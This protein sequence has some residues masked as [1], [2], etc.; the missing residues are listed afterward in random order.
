MS[1]VSIFNNEST[2]GET[3]INSSAIN[4]GAIGNTSKARTESCLPTTKRMRVAT[5]AGGKIA[6]VGL[7]VVNRRLGR[8]KLLR[9]A[10]HSF[11]FPACGIERCNRSLSRSLKAE[12]G[13]P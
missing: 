10:L 8:L 1:S 4:A 6:T 5:T 12:D 2:N 9:A 13:Q 11:L 7:G 3:I